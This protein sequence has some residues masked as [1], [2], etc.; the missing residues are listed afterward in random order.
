MEM[1]STKQKHIFIDGDKLKVIHGILDN[2]EVW[3]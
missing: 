2:R 3:E 1:Y